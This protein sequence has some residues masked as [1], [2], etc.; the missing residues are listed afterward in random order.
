MTI[1]ASATHKVLLKVSGTQTTLPDIGHAFVRDFFAAQMLSAGILP[2][3]I[4]NADPGVSRLIIWFDPNGATTVD[5]ETAQGSFKL[6][7]DGTT[8]ITDPTAAQWR[9][10][11]Q[12]YLGG[13]SS[14][15][16]VAQFGYTQAVRLAA[17]GLDNAFNMINVGG[18][19]L[20]NVAP[21]YTTGSYAAYG[22]Y[23][24]ANHVDFQ[25]GYKVINWVDWSIFPTY[26]NNVANATFDYV[27]VINFSA[28]TGNPYS[29]DGGRIALVFHKLP[30]SASTVFDST[31]TIISGAYNNPWHFYPNDGGASWQPLPI[32]ESISVRPCDMQAKFGKTAT[33][34]FVG[35]NGTA[36]SL[37]TYAVSQLIKV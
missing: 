33:Q 31:P 5:A 14:G 12:F 17:A 28:A 16:V 32:I 25:S 24:N 19:V 36:P 20:N 29:A 23:M 26:I 11:L 7:N 18:L 8:W 9:M 22:A 30:L 4:Q 27:G 3:V 1:L 34:P 2:V 21:F 15:E 13:S 35:K 10:W 6:S 37:N